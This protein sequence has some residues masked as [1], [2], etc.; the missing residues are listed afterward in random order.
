MKTKR[1]SLSLSQ[2]AEHTLKHHT[3]SSLI[4]QPF[5]SSQWPLSESI[6]KYHS[7]SWDF[8]FNHLSTVKSA[9]WHGLN[10]LG[11]LI[12]ETFLTWNVPQGWE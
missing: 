6:V 9:F 7:G 11:E 1:F 5:M 2:K 4:L 12:L 10:Y 8:K 3:A